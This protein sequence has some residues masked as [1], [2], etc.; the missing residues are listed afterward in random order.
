MKNRMIDRYS[1]LI[2]Q[3]PFALLTVMVVLTAFLAAGASKVET[4][5]QN[6][7]DLLPDSIDSVAAFDVIGAEFGQGGGSGATFTVLFETDPR[8]ANSTEIRDVRNPELLEYIERVS[9][10]LSSMNDVATVSSAADLVDEPSSRREASRQLRESGQASQFVSDDYSFTIMRVTS[11]DLSSEEQQAL[12][13]RI[14]T[15]VQVNEKPAGIET[16]YTGTPFINQAFQEQTQSTMSSTSAI[17]LIGVL[18]VVIL[19]FRSIAYGL[20]SLTALIFGIIAGFGLYGWLGLNMSPATSGAVS[21]G[22]GIAIDFG[23]QTVSRYREEREKLDIGEALSETIKGIL[24]PM[25]IALIA[26]LIGFTSLSFG[27]IT[28]LSDMGTML[29]LTTLCAY[30]GAL[31]IIP[32]SLV[33]YDRYLT[34][35]MLKVKQQ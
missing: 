23:I 11:T 13:D 17:S 4:V 10:D 12:A 7:E 27:R 8:Y 28:F 31:T 18:V 9:N 33:V 20:S 29:T 19:L 6:Q 30:I 35:I 3:R 21:M 34:K 32:I 1:R 2:V 5:E 24:N 14:K 16:G 15:S 26:A 22:M 25:T